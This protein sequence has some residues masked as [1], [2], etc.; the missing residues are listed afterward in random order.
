[1]LVTT[2]RPRRSTEKTNP[3]LHIAGLV[4]LHAIS[5]IHGVSTVNHFDKGMA[6]VDIDNACLYHTV[7]IKE[8]SQVSFR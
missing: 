1:M 7:F 3:E 8:R 6:L 5:S 4:R 2:S